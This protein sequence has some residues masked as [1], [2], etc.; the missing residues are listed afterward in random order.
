MYLIEVNSLKNALLNLVSY[1]YIIKRLNEGQI[2]GWLDVLEQK[3][4]C[5]I[6]K[7]WK[8]LIGIVN[9]IHKIS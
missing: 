1:F 5:R 8:Q 3:F 6:F 2:D 4:V 9:T 7:L